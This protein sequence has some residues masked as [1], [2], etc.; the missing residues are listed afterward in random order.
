MERVDGREVV[1][2]PANGVP[3]RQ[4]LHELDEREQVA[5][6]TTHVAVPSLLSDIDV[7][8]QVTVRRVSE[9]GSGELPRAV[10]L[11]QHLCKI[12]RL[13]VGSVEESGTEV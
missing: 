1:L 13:L 4:A 2:S 8:R 12:G 10:T 5:A 3:E 9:A 6:D 7:Q 11:P